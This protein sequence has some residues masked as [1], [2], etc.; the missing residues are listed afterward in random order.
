MTIE[1][2]DSYQTLNY[3]KWF[4]KSIIT[5]ENKDKKF[6]DSEMWSTFMIK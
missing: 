2:E 6:L 1:S 4:I 3:Q 5:K